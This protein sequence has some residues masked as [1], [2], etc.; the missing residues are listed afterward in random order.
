PRH[1]ATRHR[2]WAGSRTSPALAV[3]RIEQADP[4]VESLVPI[5]SRKESRGREEASEVA[6]PDQEEGASQAQ[7]AKEDLARQ[8]GHGRCASAWRMPLAPRALRP[9]V[10]AGLRGR[11]SRAD[12]VR[13]HTSL[14]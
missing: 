6:C 4:E 11:R 12:R 1:S 5:R 9:P 14:S 3:L 8:V 13:L 7:A 10:V 2:V